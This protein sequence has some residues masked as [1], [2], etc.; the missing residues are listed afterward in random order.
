MKHWKTY[1]LAPL[2]IASLTAGFALAEP[3]DGQGKRGDRMLEKMSSELNLTP[4]QQ[5]LLR[6]SNENRRA[7]RQGNKEK[8]QELKAL[9][10]S[11]DYSESKARTLAEDITAGSADK[12]VMSSNSAHAFYSSL[13]AE[14]KAQ[15]EELSERMQKRFKQGKRGDK[16][17]PE[18]QPA[19]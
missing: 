6:A 11:D 10:N 3:D 4:E 13:N 16:P 17:S 5:E 9:I 12:I 8:L 19:Q 2:F 15:F 14:Q 7:E 18:G 1:I